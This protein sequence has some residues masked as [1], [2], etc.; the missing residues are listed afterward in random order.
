MALE[1]VAMA[2]HSVP[3]FGN[4][5]LIFKAPYEVAFKTVP[6][7]CASGSAAFRGIK[8]FENDKSSKPSTSE[9][10][11]SIEHKE[12][13]NVSKRLHKDLTSFPSE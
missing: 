12:E 10:Q 5:S 11:S 2:G 9:L 3:R 6:F 7:G 13:N 1:S 8:C 4:G